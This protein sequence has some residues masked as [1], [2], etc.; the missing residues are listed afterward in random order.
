MADYLNRTYAVTFS[1][2]GKWMFAKNGYCVISGRGIDNLITLIKSQT[3]SEKRKIVVWNY[4][5]SEMA[6]W[7]GLDFSHIEKH[8]LRSFIVKYA[9]YKNVIFKNA[10]EFY[11]T[12]LEKISEENNL[13][14]RSELAIVWS[15]LESERLKNEGQ[16]FRIPVTSIGYISRQINNLSG[17]NNH[18]F[19]LYRL[20]K[21]ITPETHTIISNCKN[22]GL[23]GIDYGR[24]DS[25]CFVNSYDFK[26][27]YPW[28]MSTQVFPNSRYVCLHGLTENS[29]RFQRF[30]EKA[31]RGQLLWI[32]R[33]KFNFIRAKSINYLNYDSAISDTYTFT[34][35]DYKIIRKSYDYIIDEIIDFIPFEACTKLPESL[36]KYIAQQFLIKESFKK[37]TL[38]YHQAKIFLNCI[39]GLFCQNQL[40][41]GKS[42]NCF[43]AQQRP[44]VIGVFVTAYGRYFLWD[45]MRDH[46]PLIWDTDGFK[47]QDTIDLSKFNK[48]R[49]IIGNMG[50]L[51]CESEY[52]PCTVFGNKQY[53]LD[54]NLKLSGTDGKLATE[55]CKKYNIIP[56][57]GTI[58]PP[59]YTNKIIV[60]EKKMIRLPYTIGLKFYEELEKNDFEN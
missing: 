9:T 28:I 16:I 12:S 5:L 22:G 27:F 33:V 56:H 26:S 59:E 34:N 43:T 19:D 24:I 32:A 7:S 21:S 15:A 3:K 50:K 35:L 51:I 54:G 41:Y 40:N 31:E 49:N 29:A 10:K 39:F 48:S 11:R 58:I 13:P 4:H 60:K 18:G 42:I 17:F 8:S 6:I 44:M 47:T 36:R 25:P 2:T 52:S 45:I 14:F 1:E 53:I 57:V 20:G 55:Y 46:F 38:E 37:D 30:N 23:C